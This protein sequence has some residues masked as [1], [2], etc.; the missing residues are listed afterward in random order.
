[1]THAGLPER[2]KPPTGRE[3]LADIAGTNDDDVVFTSAQYVELAG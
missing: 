3:M 2:P 1:M